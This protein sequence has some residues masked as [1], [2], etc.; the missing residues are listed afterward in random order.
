MPYQ[1]QKLFIS[2]TRGLSLGDI[3]TVLYEGTE[4]LGR[5]CTS[6]HIKLWAKYK[7]VRY[8]SKL[9]VGPTVRSNQR[10]GVNIPFFYKLSEFVAAY[11]ENIDDSTLN[12][13]GYLPPRGLAS[14]E[15]FRMADFIKTTETGGYTAGEYGYDHKAVRIPFGK[16][17]C[18]S[19][20]IT[21]NGGVLAIANE[22]LTPVGGWEDTN[23]AI[24][25]FGT[26]LLGRYYGFVAKPDAS[27]YPW[28]LYSDSTTIGVD[29]QGASV[30]RCFERLR[31]SKTLGEQGDAG[32]FSPGG[33]T[34][35]PALFNQGG[36]STSIN[37]SS[38]SSTLPDGLNLITI[39][40]AWPVHVFVLSELIAVIIT[41][42]RATLHLNEMV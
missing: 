9:Y 12:G 10:Y 41:A 6:E 11:P 34:I 27:G 36:L 32:A 17:V 38:A 31:V 37:S 21:V 35:Y 5:L 1:D 25:D 3:A 2:A 42:P 15:P 20:N 22:W 16:F 40:D 26:F 19:D 39:P 4:D 18:T 33:Y 28:L 24:S 7:P 8:S 14:N 30:A 13:W 29:G 23:L